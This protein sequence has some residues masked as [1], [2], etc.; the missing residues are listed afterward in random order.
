MFLGGAS[1]TLRGAPVEGRTQRL[2]DGGAPPQASEPL[3]P[4]VQSEGLSR[5]HSLGVP[6]D[7]GAAPTRIRHTARGEA[8]DAEGRLPQTSALQ[9]CEAPTEGLRARLE[10]R[11][12]SLLL[13]LRKCFLIR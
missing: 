9:G 4:P 6:Q 11:L 8:P 12:V 5:A 1:C 2:C 13:G 7:R 3:C 10:K